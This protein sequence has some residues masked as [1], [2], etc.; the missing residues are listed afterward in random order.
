MK[1]RLVKTFD[2]EAAHAHPIQGG[3]A[4][5]LHGHRF[6]VHV[7]QTGEI[8]PELGWLIDFGEIGNAVKPVV[9]QLD[10][11]YLNEIEG[12][13]S[14]D[15][16]VIGEWIR[17]SSCGYLP[18]PTKVEVT[19][20]EAMEYDPSRI[21][22]DLLFGYPERI[23]FH[24]EAAHSLPKTPEGHKCRR[25]HGHSYEIQVACEEMRDLIWRSQTI[26]AL[27][28]YSHLNTI[29]GLENPTAEILCGWIW[30]RIEGDGLT[31]NFVSI[32][33]TCESRCIFTG[34]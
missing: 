12:L 15:P 5:Q 27:L 10:H 26:H 24:F 16:D 6:Y 3:A 7:S 4:L 18:F 30:R 33:E 29:P 23:S 31:P 13:E 21:P 9:A 28:N 32:G 17:N 8:D 14:G 1:V 2:F 19:C 11:R 22:L 20:R 25:L 34:D